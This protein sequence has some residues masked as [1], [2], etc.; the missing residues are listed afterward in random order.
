M[1]SRHLGPHYLCS[2]HDKLMCK[3]TLST[4]CN[5]PPQEDSHAPGYLPHKE[6]LSCLNGWV[7]CFPD[8][9][10]ANN[11]LYTRGIVSGGNCKG[12]FEQLP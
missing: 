12:L 8:M 4:I 9:R 10:V 2:T 6:A 5:S 7:R 1:I 3:Y 11:R